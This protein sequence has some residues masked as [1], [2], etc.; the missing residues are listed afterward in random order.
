MSAWR[1]FFI[2]YE[3]LLRIIR[4]SLGRFLKSPAAY[5]CFFNKAIKINLRLAVI[6]LKIKILYCVYEIYFNKKLKKNLKTLNSLKS[7][8]IVYLVIIQNKRQLLKRKEP[9]WAN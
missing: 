6:W 8:Y 3:I 4:N 5:G 2:I 1:S 9:Q 7:L